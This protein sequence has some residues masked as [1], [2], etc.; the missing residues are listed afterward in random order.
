MTNSIRM[1]CSGEEDQRI[2][3]YMITREKTRVRQQM[4]ISSKF[5]MLPQKIGNLV[6]NKLHF[7]H[8]KPED[9]NLSC[10]SDNV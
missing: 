1:N 3:H 10:F 4:V 8:I 2:R 6:S 7:N 5:C 9:F